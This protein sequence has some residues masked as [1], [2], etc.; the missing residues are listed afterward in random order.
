MAFKHSH[1][2]AGEIRLLS[3]Q[4]SA[5]DELRF[6][7]NHVHRDAAPQYVALSYAWGDEEAKCP[8]YLNEKLYMIRPNL[9][10]AL[11]NLQVVGVGNFYSIWVDAICINQDD[12]SERNH[13]V[14]AM[15]E[16]YSDAS[17]VIAWLGL[18]EESSYDRREA[19]HHCRQPSANDIDNRYPR[20]RGLKD[21]WDWQ[22]AML[23]LAHRPYWSRMWIVQE[24]MLAQDVHLLCGDRL[25]CWTDF[26]SALVAQETAHAHEYLQCTSCAFPF[27]KAKSSTAGDDL[28]ALLRTYC[29]SACRDI[30][31]K[32]FAIL[33]LLPDCEREF[34]GKYFPNYSLDQDTVLLITLAYIQ[35]RPG[36]PLWRLEK[37]A[38][39]RQAFGIHFDHAWLQYLRATSEGI[40]ESS[41]LN[42]TTTWSAKFNTTPLRMNL[43]IQRSDLEQKD[44][45]SLKTW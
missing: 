4:S 9:W 38:K 26:R 23:D 28:A 31:D 16:I 8:I 10:R 33:N 5:S 15:G 43:G 11:L 6:R 41:L 2:Q 12:V 44:M 22:D 30:R 20:S 19:C 1:L 35:T 40:D 34:L 39:L 32:V 21:A 25:V 13:Q 14:R 37:D 7:V 36:N 42:I 18:Q 27:L 29:R 45:A 3:L 24:L 17:S